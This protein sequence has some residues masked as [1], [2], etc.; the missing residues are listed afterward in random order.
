MNFVCFED[1]FKK[2]IKMTYRKLGEIVNFIFQNMM[3]KI[4]LLI[5]KN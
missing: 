4:Y 3:D 2:P 5:E 1:I